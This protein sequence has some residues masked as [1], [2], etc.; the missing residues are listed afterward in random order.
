MAT[1]ITA[2]DIANAA[3]APAETEIDGNRTKARTIDELIAAQAATQPTSTGGAWGFA[4]KTRF[5]PPDT[6]G[7]SSS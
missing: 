4:V 3:R 7:P 2:D 1:P 6:V 5:V